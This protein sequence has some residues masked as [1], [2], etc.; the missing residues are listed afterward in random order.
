[1]RFWVRLAT[2]CLSLLL[3]I[4]VLLHDVAG[5]QTSIDMA[6]S[7]LM[8]QQDDL[9]PACTQDATKQMTCNFDCTP[10][11]SSPRSPWRSSRGPSLRPISP[12]PPIWQFKCASRTST[13]LRPEPTS[14]ADRL[15]RLSDGPFF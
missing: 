15:H 11:C 8:N 10:H 9:G 1:M 2:V 14:R 3:L 13:L 12:G 5:A 7:T 6:T 4:G